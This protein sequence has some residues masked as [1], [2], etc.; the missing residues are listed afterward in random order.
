MEAWLTPT[1]RVIQQV[2]V[3]LGDHRRVL[4]ELAKHLTAERTAIVEELRARVLA[5]GEGTRALSPV[6]GSHAAVATPL[7]RMPGLAEQALQVL[8]DGWDAGDDP[9][10]VKYLTRVGQWGKQVGATALDFSDL[11]RL[12][13]V[14][15]RSLLPFI[16]KHLPAGPELELAFAALDALERAV[17]VV[18]AAA[19]IQIAQ[20]HLAQGAH[21]RTVGRLA[22]G[23]VHALNNILA[24]I[25]GRAQILEEEQRDEAAMAE[26]RAIQSAARAAAD[27]LRRLQ[28]FAAERQGQPPARLDVNALIGDVVQLTRFRWRDDAEAKG[29]VIDVVKDLA[30]V[31]SVL[32]RAEL[33]REALVE[34]ILNAVEAMPSGGLV[35]IRSERVGDRVHISVTDLGEG[36]DEA[37]RARATEPFFTTKGEA[38]VG[39]GLTNVAAIMR[40]HGGEFLLQSVAGRGTTATLSLPIAPEIQEAPEPRFTRLA[41]WTNILVVDDEAPV[42]EV[43]LR[44]FRGHGLRAVAAE[45][46]SEA[47]RLFQSE[48][49]FEIVLCDLGMPGMNGFEVARAIKKLNPKTIV[50][51]MTG[52]AAELDAKKMREVGIDRTINK[53]FDVEQVIQ[54]ITEALIVREKM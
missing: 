36:M 32:G 21:Q 41:R 15:R 9:N 45:S 43:A 5:W 19:Y 4:E 29:I 18:L 26:L 8:L 7:G 33:L 17:L 28:L 22:G 35:T 49:P 53:P 48:G 52:W 37:T 14:W 1:A 40:Q 31:P 12:I 47:L 20:E 10:L 11:M 42:R 24:V 3:S 23:F 46:G 54:L 27:S 38:H 50:I 39:L 16:V 51:L 6:A 13:A 30:P 34:L 44:A 25:I 2:S